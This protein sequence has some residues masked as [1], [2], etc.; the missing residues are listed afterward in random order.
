MWDGEMWDDQL[1]IALLILNTWPQKVQAL[2]MKGP[3]YKEDT[4]IWLSEN[5]MSL[6][7]ATDSLCTDRI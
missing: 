2:Q 7:N 6:H 5:Y 1:Y 3:A 4:F